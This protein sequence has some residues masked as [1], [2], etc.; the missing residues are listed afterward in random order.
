[1]SEEAGNGWQEWQKYVLKAI[2]KQDEKTGKI[3]DKIDEVKV[4]VAGLKVDV[5]ALKVKA[6]VWGLIGGAIPVIVGLGIWF[7]RSAK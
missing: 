7:L 1:M 5:S 3:F 4:D 6:G 2:E